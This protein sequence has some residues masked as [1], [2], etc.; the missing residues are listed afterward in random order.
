VL[1]YEIHMAS[2][3]PVASVVVSVHNSAAFMGAAVESVLSRTLLNLEVIVV[4]DGSTEEDL[5]RTTTRRC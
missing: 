1:I 4:D 2:K 3:F 5:V